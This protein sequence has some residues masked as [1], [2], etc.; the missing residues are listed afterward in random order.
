MDIELGSREKNENQN[1]NSSQK[2][3]NQKS[4]KHHK[5]ATKKKKEYPLMFALGPCESLDCRIIF[6]D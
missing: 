2:L 5:E 1:I 6:Y 3:V 4:T